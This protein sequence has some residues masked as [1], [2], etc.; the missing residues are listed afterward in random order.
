MPSRVLQLGIRGSIPHAAISALQLV[1]RRGWKMQAGAR[2]W[3]QGPSALAERRPPFAAGQTPYEGPP[4]A[5]PLH[6]P[7]PFAGGVAAARSRLMSAGGC[8][9]L[10]G[11]VL[12]SASPP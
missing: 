5:Q 2:M 10:E 6:R 8:W 9:M 3:C 4:A 1:G 11:P 7:K 12:A